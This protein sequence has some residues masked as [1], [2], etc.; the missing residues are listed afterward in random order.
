MAVTSTSF[1]KGESGYSRGK[2]FKTKIL[3]VIQAESLLDVCENAD[4]NT[5]ERAYLKHIAKRAFDKDDQASPTLLKELLSKSYAGLKATLPTLE[6]DFD[7]DSTPAQQVNQI[8]HASSTGIIPPDVAAI[9]I[10]SIKNAVDIEQATDL[11]ERIEAL[12][13]MLNAQHG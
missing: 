9:F 4:K 10:Q 7:K 8:L 6:F 11:K 13:K 3:E 2:S 12:E 1:K 5:V